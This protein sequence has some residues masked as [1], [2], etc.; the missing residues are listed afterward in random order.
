MPLPAIASGKR[1]MK[2]VTTWPKRLPG[3]GVAAERLAARIGTLSGGR[4]EIKVYAANELV[5]ALE[6]F[7]TVSRGAADMSHGASYYW[8]G[9][10]KAFNFF[11]G[12]PFGMTA[13]EISAWVRYLGGQALRDEVTAPFGCVSFMAGQTGTQA[14]G[15]FRK[16]L[17]GLA[18]VKG[19]KFRT[20]GLG[21]DVWKKLGVTVV[22]LPAGEIFQSLQS[23]AIDATEFVGPS[24]DIA[25][26]F[27]QVAK[28]YYWPSFNEPGLAL[29]LTVNKKVYDDLPPDL[30]AII[31]YA[32]QA[33]CEETYAELRAHDALLK[34]HKVLSVMSDRA[35][36]AFLDARRLPVKYG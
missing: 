13:A 27:W 25:L 2:M 19:L 32:C 11:T 34:A 6:A 33:D 28:N 16:E 36:R 24:I 30:Q 35:D 3:L 9:K 20:P 1:E 18:D 26:G 7:D 4:L 31:Q 8:Q 22:N 15:W 17:T 14:A 21:G 23:G 5:P 29:E 10:S 12:V